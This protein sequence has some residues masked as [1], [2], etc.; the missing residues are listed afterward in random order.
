MVTANKPIFKKVDCLRVYVDNLEK[1]LEFYRDKLGHSIIWRSEDAIGLRIP[2]QDTEIVIQ[3]RD[4]KTEVNLLV[5]SVSEAILK[6][7]E[8]GGSLI[9]GPIDIPIGKYATLKDP[10]NN[11]LAILDTSKGLF[12]TDKEGNIIGQETK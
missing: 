11:E 7:K 4:K 2:E 1:G 8:A 10:W 9:F 6:I 5:D 3:T 12:I